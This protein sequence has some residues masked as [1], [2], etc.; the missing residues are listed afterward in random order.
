MAIARGNSGAD[1][2]SGSTT[3]TISSFDSGSPSSGILFVLTASG[4]GNAT[5][6]TW[7]GNAMTLIETKAVSGYQ[8][9]LWGYLAP[10]GSGNIVAT[11]TTS[12]YFVAVAVTYSGVNQSLTLDA[13][14]TD[15]GSGVSTIETSVTVATENSWVVNCSTVG[16]IVNSVTNGTVFIKSSIGTCG[17][18]TGPDVSFFDSN[19]AQT[20]GSKSMTI[21]ICDTSDGN[22]IMF[23]VAPSAAVGPANMK[24]WDGLAKASVKTMDGLAIASVKT[25]NGLA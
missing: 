25:W 18:T 24:T 8:L 10:T 3:R 21:N 6:V 14:T 15:N 17:A 20:T 22:V 13:I 16:N 23:S 19:G 2:G 1:R 5:G 9:K 4:T 11:Q 7:A 12:D